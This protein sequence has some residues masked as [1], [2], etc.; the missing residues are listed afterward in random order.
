MNSNRV[1]QLPWNNFSLIVS[2]PKKRVC[3][4]RHLRIL[5]FWCEEQ[6]SNLQETRF[7]LQLKIQLI[8][9]E[10]NGSSARLS[11]DNLTINRQA[12][13]YPKMSAPT[14]FS[15]ASTEFASSRADLTAAR[16]ASIFSSSFRFSPRVIA[17]DCLV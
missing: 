4:F 10:P 5:N 6:D 12:N 14:F 17:P 16:T 3:Q 2:L 8:Q 1:F 9:V 7:Q 11:E 13:I 15:G